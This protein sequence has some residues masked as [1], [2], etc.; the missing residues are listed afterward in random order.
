MNG[1]EPNHS[2]KRLFAPILLL[3][4]MTLVGALTAAHPPLARAQL[5]PSRHYGALTIDGNPAPAGTT[6]DAYIGSTNCG[7]ATTTEDGRYVLDVA[8][9]A[10]ILGCGVEDE[11]IVIAVNGV[12]ADQTST[13]QLGTFV[14]LD[15]N[16]P[17]VG[18]APPAASTDTPPPPQDAPPED[19]P[20]P[21]DEMTPPADNPAPPEDMAPPSDDNPPP[22]APP[23]APAPDEP[24]A[25]M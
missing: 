1:K 24:P 16:A 14:L 22:D 21:P 7:S 15:N 12:V 18:A 23:A 10:T 4:A 19:N 2:V 9:G 25:E 17:S 5:P 13:F 3:G 6:I 11:T 20:P 8:A